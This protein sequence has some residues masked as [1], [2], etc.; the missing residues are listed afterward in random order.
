MSNQAWSVAEVESA[1]KGYFQLLESELSGK[2]VN[3]ARFIRELNTHIKD[4]TKGSI[5]YKFGN[6]SA[7]L[8]EKGL[9]FLN[10]YAPYNKYQNLLVNMTESYL[11]ENPNFRVLLEKKSP[12]SKPILI[13]DLR[14]YQSYIVPVPKVSELKE[15]RESYPRHIDFA[16]KDFRNRL[17]GKKGE[18]FVYALEKNNLEKQGLDKLATK[19]KWVSLEEGDGAGFDILS[20]DAKG[21]E[22]YIEVKTTTLNINTSFYMSDSEIKFSKKHMSDFYM[23]RLYDFFNERRFYVADTEKL[24]KFD[25]KPLQFMLSPTP[26][27]LAGL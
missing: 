22:K 17:L 18:E 12:I 8:S 24:L 19:V 13:D 9:D 1:I 15:E 20:F 27:Q 5:E 4:R 2:A 10:G 21:R 11:D 26:E 16:A 7:V 23:H 14:P 3:K 25:I 6:I